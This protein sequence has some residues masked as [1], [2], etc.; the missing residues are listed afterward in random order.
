MKD[1][2]DDKKDN[3][4]KGNVQHIHLGQLST[5]KPV[6]CSKSRYAKSTEY[7]AQIHYSHHL[8]PCPQRR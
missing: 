6:H 5:V 7:Q 8:F 2:E 1:K 3:P 4:T